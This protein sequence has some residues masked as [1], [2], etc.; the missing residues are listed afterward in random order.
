MR[1]I[2]HIFRKAKKQQKACSE[3]K[4]VNQRLFLPFTFPFVFPDFFF[5]R[6]LSE[7]SSDPRAFLASA[8][9]WSANGKVS[10]VECLDINSNTHPL[11]LSALVHPNRRLHDILRF[12]RQISLADLRHYPRLRNRTR[13]RR[14]RWHQN[15]HNHSRRRC[16]NFPLAPQS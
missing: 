13:W 7:S 16:L 15:R 9:F 12:S 6:S 10:S 4:A 2:V 1:Y 3:K 8:R 14:Y 5:G 11:L